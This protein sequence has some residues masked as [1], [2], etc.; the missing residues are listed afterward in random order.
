LPF[1]RHPFDRIISAYEDKVLTSNYGFK[2]KL[3]ITYRDSSFNSFVR[4]ILDSAKE[5][6][7]F[8]QQVSGC[9]ID[10]HI[11]PYLPQCLYCDVDFDVIEQLGLLNYVQHKTPG[12]GDKSK[13]ERRDKY[14]SKLSPQMVQDLYEL[15]KIDFEMFSYDLY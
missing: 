15:Y 9:K 11:R 4:M 3:K 7:C 5:R 2:K 13:R 6:D 10:R 1:V 14:I 12:N 8:L